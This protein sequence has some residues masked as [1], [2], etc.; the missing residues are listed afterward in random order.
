[1]TIEHN[2]VEQ[3]KTKHRKQQ[4]SPINEEA[5][6]LALRKRIHEL[7]NIH[8]E[9]TPKIPTPVYMII[10]K[11]LLFFL[12]AGVFLY[13]IYIF[14]CFDQLGKDVYIPFIGILRH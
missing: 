11:W 5:E 6:L 8:P 13:S 9:L 2:A 10:L 4:T 12:I 3:N 1:M 14:Y 7:E